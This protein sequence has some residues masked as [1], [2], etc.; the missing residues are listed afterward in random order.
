[1][2]AEKLEI[3]VTQSIEYT[4]ELFLCTTVL[5]R[6]FEIY[7]ANEHLFLM[8]CNVS[9]ESPKYKMAGGSKP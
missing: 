6:F 4:Y 1:M 9:S 5:H 2:A 3:L 7:H 8:M